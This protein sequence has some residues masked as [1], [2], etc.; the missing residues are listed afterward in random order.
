MQKFINDK[1]LIDETVDRLTGFIPESNIYVSTTENYSEGI[2]ELLPNIPSENI[3]VEPV[4]RGTTAAFALFTR[5]IQ[6]RDPE[7][8]IFSLASD[9]AV[10][11]I[12]LFKQTIQNSFDFIA[13][14]PKTISLVGIKPTRADSGL[15]YIKA[16][17][18]FSEEPLSYSIEKYIEKPNTDVAKAYL[19]SGG[20]FWNAAYYCFRA[21]TL[22][23]AYNEADPEVVSHVDKFIETNQ[24]EYFKNIPQKAHE[25]E[26]ID[27]KKYPLYVIPA[28]FE[29]SDIGNWHTIHEVL[30]K[31]SGEQNV[32]NLVSN[33]TH[34]DINSSDSLVF[35]TDDRLIATVGLKNLAVI[36]TPDV[37]LIIDKDQ[38]Q[39]IKALL[40]SIKDKGLGQY[41]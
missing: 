9:H 16:D 21:D 10:A 30:S 19:E 20:Y 15:G 14:N 8:I 7:A 26:F 37:L 18:V 41:L 35:S 38:P 1:T 13:K 22:V 36:S 2:K 34:V 25:I 12:D 29:W 6:N 40:E 32:T 28:D 23:E 11:G 3:I 27:S 24:K 17:H 31:I 5:T 39:E 4:A 33:G